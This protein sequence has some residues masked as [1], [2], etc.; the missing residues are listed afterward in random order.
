MLECRVLSSQ[1]ASDLDFYRELQRLDPSQPDTRRALGF[2]R[3]WAE[4][5]RRALAACA[6]QLGREVRYPPALA[7]PA[8]Q[9]YLEKGAHVRERDFLERVPATWSGVPAQLLADMTRWLAGFADPAHPLGTTYQV[10]VGAASD[11]DI[12]L[13]GPSAP[14]PPPP[15]KL[16]DAPPCLGWI[17]HSAGMPVAVV[18]HYDV[19]GLAM[20]AATLRTL[21]ATGVERVDCILNFEQ[22]GDISKLWK[23]TVPRLISSEEPYAAVIMIDCSIHSRHPDRTRK[24][25]AR[26]DDASGTQLVMIDHHDDTIAFAPELL[27]PRLDLV[28]TDVP[29]CG[30][31]AETDEQTQ[32]LM[33]L[34]ALGDKVPEVTAAYSRETH[35]QLH[36]ANYAYHQRLVHFSPTP[37]EMKQQG[38]QPMRPLWEKLAAGASVTPRLAE[39]VLGE[40]LSPPEPVLPESLRCGELLFVTSPLPAVGRT[41]YAL[42][43]RLMAQAGTSYAAALRILDGRRANML[44]LTHWE[45]THL[46]PVRHFVPP[47]YLHRCLGHMAAV[48]VDVPKDEALILLESVA[49]RLNGFMQTIG[50][51][52]PVAQLLAR[53]II[54][55]ATAP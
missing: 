6:A 26:L 46:P 5:A 54:D 48:W 2:A 35:L 25:I 21:Q 37:R 38:V 36:E 30:L 31:L 49:R 24:A 22:T 19:H 11:R 23:R 29:S 14:P 41:W 45:A 39:D 10:W 44:L 3:V 28:L 18:A 16:L 7:L 8:L 4:L 34:G 12:R 53:N 9:A 55:P 51:F 47:E 13:L 15:L 33:V 32:T 52:Q 1:A 40:L 17:A 42:L 43:E 27:H 50:N 20:L